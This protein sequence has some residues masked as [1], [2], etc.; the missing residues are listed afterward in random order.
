MSNNPPSFDRPA[1]LESRLLKLPPSA[2]YI[3]MVLRYEGQLSQQEVQ[4]VTL[5][6]RRTISHSLAELE[7]AD[8]VEKR[9][10]GGDARVREY[11][12]RPDCKD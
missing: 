10:H 9:I 2:K 4:K 5:L 7:E 6:P 3:Y 12:A 1:E 11:S 8:L